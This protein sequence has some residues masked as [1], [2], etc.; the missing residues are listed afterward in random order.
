[1]ETVKFAVMELAVVH[2]RKQVTAKQQPYPGIIRWC[3]RMVHNS[4]RHIRSAKAA[5]V[6]AII[7][8]PPPPS[9]CF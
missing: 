6:R 3:R 8:T 5:G 4:E 7:W 2:Y 1:M 9:I